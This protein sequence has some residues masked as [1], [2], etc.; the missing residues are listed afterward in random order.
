MNHL[1][2]QQSKSE[3]LSSFCRKEQRLA[4][5]MGGLCLQDTKL[6]EEKQSWELQRTGLDWKDSSPCGRPWCTIEKSKIYL[7][8]KTLRG[9]PLRRAMAKKD[10]CGLAK[11]DGLQGGGFGSREVHSRRWWLLEKHK[12]WV[13]RTSLTT[14]Q[15]NTRESTGLSHKLQLVMGLGRQVAGEEKKAMKSQREWK[16]FAS[17]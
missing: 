12:E 13:K 6:A 4:E 16:R 2:I 10:G 7:S 9:K 3:G 15:S 17:C 5:R 11:Q 14:W 8:C 1:A